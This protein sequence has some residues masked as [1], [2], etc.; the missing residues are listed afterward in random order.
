MAKAKRTKKSPEQVALDRVYD[1]ACKILHL[2]TLVTRNR[3]S[4]DFHEVSVGSL[5]KALN[6]AFEAGQKNKPSDKKFYLVH[7]Q[8]QIDPYIVGNTH[9]D[10]DS[11][12]SETRKFIRNKDY[13]EGLDQVFYLVTESNPTDGKSEV[14]IGNFD[15]SDL[16]N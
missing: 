14:R 11:L 4:L 5:T 2:D 10:F 3:D 16:E 7:V 12:A 6:M 1:E 15:S 13:Q 8:D 9:S